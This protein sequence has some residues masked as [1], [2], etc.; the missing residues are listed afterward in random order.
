MEEYYVQIGLTQKPMLTKY[1]PGMREIERER[2]FI[3]FYRIHS[4]IPHQQ[5]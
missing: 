2:K 4:H 1:T 5:R 3:L